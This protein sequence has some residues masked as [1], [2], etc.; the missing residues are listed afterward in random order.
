MVPIDKEDALYH[1]YVD[2]SCD[3]EWITIHNWKTDIDPTAVYDPIFKENKKIYTQDVT[4]NIDMTIKK[5]VTEATLRFTFYRKNKGSIEEKL[6][7][8]PLQNEQTNKPSISV[9]LAADIEDSKVELE[10]KMVDQT[11]P[12][13]TPASLSCK[14]SN[15]IEHT[16]SLWLQCLLILLLGALLSLTPCI[17]P[18]IP[19]TV[20]IL[21]GQGSTSFL[22]NLFVSLCYT[23]GVATTFALLGTVA[24][25]TG[26]LFG[27][28]MQSPIVILS[29]VALLLYLALSMFGLYDMY[30]P[31]GFQS[32]NRFT[33][34]GSPITAFLFGVVSG[35]VASPCVSPGLALVLSIVTG[36]GN[37]FLGFI[38]LFAFGI[39]LSLPL[40]IIGTFSSSLNVLPKAGMWMVEIKKLFG[41]LMVGM[42]IYFL[43]TIIPAYTTT[44]L[45]TLL[46]LV[47]GLYYLKAASKQS[48][49]GKLLYNLL[50]MIL[51]TGS[52]IFGY[53][54]IRASFNPQD[55]TIVGLWTE[56]YTCARE[57][58][59][60][61][62]KKLLLKVE[63]P[64]CSMCTAID[65]KFFRNS[66][67]ITTLEQSYIPVHIDGSDTV[68]QIIPDLVKKFSI[69]GFPTIL[70]IDPIDEVILKK[71]ASDLYDYSIDEF[72]QVLIDSAR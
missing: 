48:T 37:P 17:Y 61:E 2:F 32:N 19:I 33:K 10:N 70:I 65:K 7:H 43:G 59:R 1:E 53:F 28:F 13:I 21:Q 8:L 72:K 35:T 25:Y 60:H 46:I 16:N 42:S 63:A 68:D 55:C 45:F 51:I 56:N 38:F 50:G 34:G 6:I 57:Q 20:G 41:F 47:A 22:R 4:F 14:I 9:N 62:H 71:W 15:L 26:K 31:K 39:G 24:A 40:M 58:A 44:W 23:M 30:I 12:E 11:E 69:V 52:I 5:P 66:E 3:Q 64:C 36:L 27:T 67:I 18:M 49:L 29:I 54:A